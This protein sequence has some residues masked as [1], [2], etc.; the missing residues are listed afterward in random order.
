MSNLDKSKLNRYDSV[1]TPAPHDRATIKS[2]VDQPQ[3]L[4]LPGGGVYQFFETLRFLEILSRF[5]LEKAQLSD[6]LLQ[7]LIPHKEYPAD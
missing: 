4:R 3:L 5:I 1:T 2:V 6:F 7:V